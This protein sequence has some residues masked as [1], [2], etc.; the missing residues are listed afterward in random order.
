MKFSEGVRKWKHGFD[1]CDTPYDLGF[2]HAREEDR[3]LDNE[4]PNFRPG[5]VMTRN[6]L[7]EYMAGYHAGRASR[8]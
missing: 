8:S 1:G 7:S 5:C 3:T 4:Y 2:A 6:E